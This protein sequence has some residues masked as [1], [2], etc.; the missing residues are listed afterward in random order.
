MLA[1]VPLRA[2]ALPEPI[3]RAWRLAMREVLGGALARGFAVVDL[4]REGERAF[5]VLRREG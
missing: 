2:D 4:A 5:Y 1:E 3:R